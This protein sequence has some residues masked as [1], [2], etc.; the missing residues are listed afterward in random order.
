[1]AIKDLG[2]LPK[3]KVTINELLSQCDLSPIREYLDKNGVGICEAILIVVLDTGHIEWEITPMLTSRL[4]YILEKVKKA[5][6]EFT[7]E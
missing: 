4:I 3:R 5:E 2:K 7:E 6:I 1:M